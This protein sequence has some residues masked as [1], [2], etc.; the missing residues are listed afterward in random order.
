MLSDFII[1]KH[2][3]MTQ[4]KMESIVY[5]NNVQEDLKL[6]FL[7]PVSKSKIIPIDTYPLMN[8]YLNQSLCSGNLKKDL[9]DYL[10]RSNPNDLEPLMISKYREELISNRYDN[11]IEILRSYE[12]VVGKNQNKTIDHAMDAL[13]NF[14]NAKKEIAELNTSINS[15]KTQIDE[16]GKNIQ[17]AKDSYITIKNDQSKTFSLYAFMV[18]KTG[19]F[20]YEIDINGQRAILMAFH[21]QFKSKGYFNIQVRKM[22]DLPVK[23]KEEFGGFDQ[24]WP[25]FAEVDVQNDQQELQKASD[26]IKEEEQKFNEH[27][28]KL[29][30][31]ETAVKT[32]EIYC[33]KMLTESNL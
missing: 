17:E 4:R 5:S 27:N 15:N 24:T 8:F 13:N 30:E 25:M 3:N 6:L 18:G 7:H 28:K 12:D 10:S 1:V 22:M 21:T 16:Q 19:N 14:L 9:A 32:K 33:K 31:D 29:Q 26:K 23:I 2:P 20:E 11:S